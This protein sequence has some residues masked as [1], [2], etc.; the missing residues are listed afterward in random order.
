[1]SSGGTTLNYRIIGVLGS[2]SSGASKLGLVGE[3]IMQQ[4]SQKMLS[5]KR[6]T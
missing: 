4:A 2:F 3:K 5:R 6:R 1:M